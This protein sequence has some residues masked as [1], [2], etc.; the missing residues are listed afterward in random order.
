MTHRRT[1][2][3]LSAWLFCDYCTKNICGHTQ[4]AYAKK[5][6]YVKRMI[7]LM[8]TRV[9][10]SKLLTWTPYDNTR[11]LFRGCTAPCP[12]PPIACTPWSPRTL[13]PGQIFSINNARK[14]KQHCKWIFK[15]KRNE[16]LT[17]YSRFVHWCT[18][19]HVRGIRR[20]KAI[21]S[22]RRAESCERRLDSCHIWL[23]S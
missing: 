20:L 22:P 12:P 1:T 6:D 21:D 4:M 8:H 14:W 11:A 18:T 15:Y 7:N 23:P 10:L 17:S 3:W 9:V 5:F 2:S 16:L 19:S 13:D